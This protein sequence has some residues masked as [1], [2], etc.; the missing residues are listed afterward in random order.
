MTIVVSLC[1]LILFFFGWT[2]FAVPAGK[3]G[4]MLSKSGGYHAEVIR[5]GSMVWRWERL[6]PTNAKIFV[7]DLSPRRITYTLDGS[8]PAA[9]RY[10]QILNNKDDFSWSFS[11][12]TLVSIKPEQL[13]TTVSNRNIRTQEALDSFTDSQIQSALQSIMHHYITLL[14]EDS[15]LYQKVKTDYHAFSEMFK[16]ELEKK[17]GTQFSIDAVTIAK[18][19]VPD[20][21][22]Y[23]IAEQAYTLYEQTREMLLAETA[24]KEAQRAASEQFQIERL[25]KWGDFLAKYPAILELIAV[26]QKDSKAA[27]DALRAVEK[28]ED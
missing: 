20:L 24:A 16:Q 12:D 19:S 3:Y 25:A 1:V 18:I 11:V 21:N 2:Q 6:I 22:T 10:M 9:D 7:F 4:V 28:K 5:S 8:L 15:Y 13:V 23:K 14:L 26:A 27:L 17:V